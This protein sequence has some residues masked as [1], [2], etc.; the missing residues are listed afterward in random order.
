VTLFSDGEVEPQL[1]CSSEQFSV[2]NRGERQALRA[3]Q[4]HATKILR[5]RRRTLPRVEPG[6]APA[7]NAPDPA[8]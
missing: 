4:I 8:A 6:P 5:E 2:V 3:A 1:I 7:S